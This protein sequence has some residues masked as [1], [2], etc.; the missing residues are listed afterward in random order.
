L[1]VTARLRARRFFL[2]GLAL[3]S[4]TEPAALDVL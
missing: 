4:P 3:L 2:P 1:V